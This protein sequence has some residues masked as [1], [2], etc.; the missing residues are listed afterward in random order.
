MRKKLESRKAIKETGK[1][2]IEP[3][4]LADFKVPE[5]PL[6]RIQDIYKSSDLLRSRSESDLVLTRSQPK[7]P[8]KVASPVTTY[9]D[10]DDS[11]TAVKSADVGSAT[12]ATEFKDATDNSARSSQTV[13]DDYASEM[14]DNYRTTTTV[15]SPSNGPRS[16]KYVSSTVGVKQRSA[17][18]HDGQ[19]GLG[20]VGSELE[21]PPTISDAEGRSSI[22]TE[23]ADSRSITD[24]SQEKSLAA[25]SEIQD[26]SRSLPSRSDYPTRSVRVPTVADSDIL[27]YSKK[28][29]FLQL[30]NKN[31]SEDISSIENDIKA[32][33]EIMTRLSNE[34]SDKFKA[35]KDDAQ[36]SRD[37]S[38]MISKTILSDGGGNTAHEQKRTISSERD[39]NAESAS[40]PASN[41]RSR[42]PDEFNRDK[43]ISDRIMSDEIS[44]IIS[45]EVPTLSSSAHEIDYEAKSKEIMNQIEKSIIS[46]KMTGDDYDAASLLENENENLLSDIV[47]ELDIRSISEILSRASQG[48]R[49]VELATISAARVVDDSTKHTNEQ[50]GIL[51]E[52]EIEEDLVLDEDADKTLLS[53]ISGHS[54]TRSVHSPII[55]GH[56][57]K[58][59]CETHSQS[60][61]PVGTSHA[62]ISENVKSS[63]D[64]P[65]A[66]EI[67]TGVVDDDSKILDDFSTDIQPANDTVNST[68]ASDDRDRNRSRTISAGHVAQDKEDWTTSDS[69]DVPRD[70][71]STGERDTELESTRSRLEMAAFS[72]KGESTNVEATFDNAPAVKSSSELD[73]ILDI[74]ARDNEEARIPSDESERIDDAIS[75]S[76]AELLDKVEDILQ[77]EGERAEGILCDDHLSINDSRIEFLSDASLLDNKAQRE[78][79]LGVTS[80]SRAFPTNTR[81]D[82]DESNDREGMIDASSQAVAETDVTDLRAGIDDE[83]EPREPTSEIQEVIIT[84][85]DSDSVEEHALSELEADANVELAEEEEEST[86]SEA[87]LDRDRRAAKEENKGVASV[88]MRECLEPIVEQDSSDGEQLDNLVEVAESGLDTVEKFVASSQESPEPMVDRV[89]SVLTEEAEQETADETI[90]ESNDAPVTDAETIDALNK[91]FDILK[92]P[93]YEDISEESLEVSE[94]LDKHDDSRAGTTRKPRASLPETYRATQKSEEVLRILEEISQ[95]STSESTSDESQKNKEDATSARSVTEEISELLGVEVSAGDDDHSSRSNR[96]TRDEAEEESCEDDESRARLLERVEAQKRSMRT[97][98][99]AGLSEEKSTVPLRSEERD[100][101]EKPSGMMYELRERVSQLQEQDGSSESSEAGDTPRGVSEIEMDSP[102]DFNDSRLDIDVLDDDLLSGTKT[103]GQGDGKNNFHSAP[104]VATSEKDIEAMI[105][106]LKGIL[107]YSSCTSKSILCCGII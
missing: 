32:L 46:G 78:S 48:R 13:F 79:S 26:Y 25:Q 56:R 50:S 83:E 19:A 93:E 61:F 44:M 88:E 59:S 84:E 38:E 20:T 15:S 82:D 17:S 80:G 39:I 57:S 16:E 55:A 47:T 10:R 76:V 5:I 40:V 97:S 11:K 51:N 99:D 49:S 91:T 85:L 92:D 45:E 62:T 103:T 65:E 63:V 75:N 29:D 86:S 68:I 9:D 96:L 42:S 28:L 34:S 77:V 60:P 69:F 94:I 90:K 106:K 23:S 101:D 6:K 12:S 21:I 35:N 102:R 95:K 71:I 36:T 66:L 74:I 1:L 67:E 31:L 107:Y 53:K 54:D 52:T 2:A 58:E 24:Q 81:N 33:S 7:D 73:D 30:N 4:S 104:I 105:D 98:D 43:Y 89:L 8:L 72:P 27:A 3:K 22:Q 41:G 14:F 37:I 18:S 100:A 70:E 87:S 64:I